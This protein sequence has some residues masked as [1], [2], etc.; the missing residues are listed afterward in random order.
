MSTENKKAADFFDL[1][2][3][4]SNLIVF[5]EAGS[6]CGCKANR[7]GSTCG[8][9]RIRPSP[10]RLRSREGDAQ[11]PLVDRT[12]ETVVAPLGQDV[13][14]FHVGATMSWRWDSLNTARTATT[15]E[16]MLTEL[17]GREGGGR[18]K[19]ERPW[20]R[21]DVTLRASLPHGKPIPSSEVWAT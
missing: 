20:L 17:L 19:T 11:P 14:P 10:S 13:E 1:I 4:S 8:G 7:G 21:V 12:A 9:G 3:F 6:S 15:E 16:D 2:H 5:D 18:V